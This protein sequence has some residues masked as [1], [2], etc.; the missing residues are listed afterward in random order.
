MSQLLTLRHAGRAR[1]LRTAADAVRR[2]QTGR[3]SDDGCGPHSRTA[4]GG[5]R[6]GGRDARSRR[7]DAAAPYR[8]RPGVPRDHRRRRRRHLFIGAVR[9]RQSAPGLLSARRRDRRRSAQVEGAAPED[10]AQAGGPHLPRRRLAGR[11]ASRV[12]RPST[13]RPSTWPSRSSRISTMARP[14]WSSPWPT[15]RSPDLT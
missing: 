10:V 11:R 7:S 14:T 4:P 12:P 2:P 9:R 3:R 5:E 1:A 6:S 15:S 8:Q 13:R